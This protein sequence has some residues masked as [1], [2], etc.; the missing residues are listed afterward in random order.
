MSQESSQRER[1]LDDNEIDSSCKGLKFEEQSEIIEEGSS[2]NDDSLSTVIPVIPKCVQ[3]GMRSTS[4]LYL[5]NFY[6]T[7]KFN[8]T[9]W[10]ITPVIFKVLLEL[11]GGWGGWV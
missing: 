8:F 9:F 11:L 10:N 5:M 1:S 4:T 3:L 7:K 6:G 2:K